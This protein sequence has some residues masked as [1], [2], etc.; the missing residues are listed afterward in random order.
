MGVCSPFKSKQPKNKRPRTAQK[1]AEPQSRH[2]WI[3]V[4][5]RGKKLASL[6]WR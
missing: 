1:R 3:G 2:I 5:R 4:D 6:V